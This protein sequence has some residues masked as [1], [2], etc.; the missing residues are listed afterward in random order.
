MV[1]QCAGCELPISDKF[2][3]KVLDRVWHVKCVH[4]YDCKCALTN[5][6]FSR[7][8]KLFC[9]N[10]F[11]RRYGT[12]CAGCCLGISPN[13][14]VRRAKH[15]VF[16]VKCF[17][18]S[19]CNRQILTGDELYY[20]GESKFVCKEDYYQSRLP[21]KHSDSDSEE[22]DL[23]YGLD[24]DLD[25]ALGTKRRG[26]RTTIKA[27]QLEALKAT[28]A[29]TPK[30]SRNIREKL[31]QETGLNMRVIQVWFQNRRSKERRLKQQGVSQPS[32]SRAVRSGRRSR[33]A[34]G[35]NLGNGST[36]P[37]EQSIN[38]S[39]INYAAPQ[40]SHFPATAFDDF[41]MKTDA[42]LPNEVNTTMDNS[43]MIQNTGF[44][45]QGIMAVNSVNDNSS[46]LQ[47]SHCVVA[48]SQNGGLTYDTAAGRPPNTIP[49]SAEVW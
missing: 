8:G 40:N 7:E 36:N 37:A 39:H 10:D 16:H 35:E 22:K 27:K 3:L 14:M 18:C 46:G 23:S 44:N 31:A 26:P 20:V 25:V 34:K 30:P 29:A 17:N 45:N 32:A 21:S 9:K 33:R 11:Y 6:C 41:Y 13:D 4:C 28:F 15:L 2:L 47:I 38:T 48:Q 19:S 42:G 49:P 24:E 12:K 43:Q 1:Q 5:K